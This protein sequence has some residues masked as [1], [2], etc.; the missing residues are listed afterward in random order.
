MTTFRAVQSCYQKRTISSKA[1]QYLLSP[2]S[3]MNFFSQR[4]TIEKDT[5]LGTDFLPGPYDVICS[6]GKAAYNH[7]GNSH[8]RSIIEGRIELYA[9]AGTKLEKSLAVISIVGEIRE[10]SPEGGFV[11]FNKQKNCYVEVGDQK[12]R[13]KIGHALRELM[14]G[15]ANARESTWKVAAK[16]TKAPKK[17]ECDQPLHWKTA[18]KRKSLLELFATG[19]DDTQQPKTAVEEAEECV[20]DF[21]TSMNTNI[22]NIEED[23]HEPSPPTRQILL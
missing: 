11:K 13:E 19:F 8:F 21:L 23:L 4:R 10:L 1:S 6:R 18:Q 3:I 20:A 5:P 17:S 7:S 15:R 14:N 16:E 9:R 2:S 12:A 22:G